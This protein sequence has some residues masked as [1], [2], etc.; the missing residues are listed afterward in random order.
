MLHFSPIG[1]GFILFT[2]VLYRDRHFNLFL[3]GFFMLLFA[4]VLNLI[5]AARGACVI[6]TIIFLIRYLNANKSNKNHNVTEKRRCGTK[7]FAFVTSIFFIVEF[8]LS[9]FGNITWWP[10]ILAMIFAII[11]VKCAEAGSKN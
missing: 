1:G 10:F 5:A 6:L 11:Y 7:K 2:L 9:L 3:G 8:L 4:L